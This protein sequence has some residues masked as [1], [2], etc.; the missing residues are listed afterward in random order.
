MRSTVTARPSPA[1]G[2]RAQEF[3][4]DA[5][6]DRRAPAGGIVVAPREARGARS[7]RSWAPLRPS[8]GRHVHAGRADEVADE[9]VGRAARTARPAR[10]PAPRCPRA[11]PRRCRRRSAPRSGRGDLDHCEVERR[12]SAL[13]F[14]RSS[15]FRLRVDRR[16]AARRTGSR[17][18]VG[19]D[20]PAPE[21]D[22]L[23]G[24]GRW[25]PRALRSSDLRSGQRRDSR[26]ARIDRP[27]ALRRG[28][29]AGR[30]DSRLGGHGVVDDRKLKHLGD[31]SL[32]RRQMRDVP[33]IEQYPAS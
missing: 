16:S 13:S 20:Q 27:R 26:D 32:L 17:R 6:L 28:C 21:R 10:R 25:A 30:R 11:S 19:A 24:V 5:D 31:V 2:E 12:C 29:A 8:A 1:P 18:H 22:L 9:G 23:L 3:R 15:H 14:E 33:A 7:P 4:P